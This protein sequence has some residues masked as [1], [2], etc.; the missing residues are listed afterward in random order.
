[1]QHLQLDPKSLDDERKVVLS[2]R[3]SRY[4]TR[5][6]GKIYLT[7][8]KELFKG[9]PYGSSVIG[10]INDLKTVSRQKVL[11]Y[12][13]TYYQPNNAVIVV[14]GDVEAKQVFSMIEDRLGDVETNS[15]LP[16]IKADH[17]KKLGGFEFKTK[18]PKRVY[19]KGITPYP[20]Y[21]IAFKGIKVGGRDA[22]ILDILSSVLGDGESSYLY[23]NLVLNKKPKM[24]M[25]YAA[26]Y[27]MQESGVFFIGGQLLPTTNLKQLE[28]EMKKLL[29]RSC[30]KALSK[31]ALQKVKNQYL[32]GMVS[33]LDTNA[34]IAEFI[35]QRQVYYGD[36][37]F[38]K[39]EMDIYNSI[40]LDELKSACQKYIKDQPALELSIW[41]NH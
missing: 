14:V 30:D 18:L 38:Y 7:M 3:K 8:M 25:V 29:N 12:F 13:N 24:A 39:K 4:E 16:K 1:M 33:S 35:G 9:T 32:F 20:M 27:T 26:N 36:Y 31:R 10:E 34:G 2:E 37:N 40:T 23:Q 28:R 11:D 6:Q 5:D 21:Q 19:L 41:K 17:L 22:F 15:D